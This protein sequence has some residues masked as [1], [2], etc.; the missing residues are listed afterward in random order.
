MTTFIRALDRSQYSRS[1]KSLGRLGEYQC[2]CGKRFE[3]SISVVNS[4]LKRGEKVFCGE[5]KSAFSPVKLRPYE[6]EIP[7]PN[8]LDSLTFANPVDDD[9]PH[10]LF[11]DDPFSEDREVVPAYFDTFEE[12]NEY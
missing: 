12:A 10:M 2:E 11:E 9:S 3:R 6:M 1:G 4:R 7:L 8:D 5:H